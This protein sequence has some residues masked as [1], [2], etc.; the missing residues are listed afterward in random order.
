MCGIQ[1]FE[2]KL[3]LSARI[4]EESPESRTYLSSVRQREEWEETR[5][6]LKMVMERNENKAREGEW[7]DPDFLSLKN[8][9]NCWKGR[10][11]EEW[12]DWV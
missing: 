5:Q 4:G 6:G 1:Y 7:S 11:D 2:S 10:N 12:G 3:S 8:P 9:E